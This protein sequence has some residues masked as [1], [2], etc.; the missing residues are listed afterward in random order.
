MANLIV[1]FGTY[2]ALPAVIPVSTTATGDWEAIG[3][4]SLHAALADADDATSI[5]SLATGNTS[6]RVSFGV[7]DVGTAP[8]LRIRH[9]LD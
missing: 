6:A 9:Q 2:L 5:R 8:T 4:A 7:I 3:A 1:F